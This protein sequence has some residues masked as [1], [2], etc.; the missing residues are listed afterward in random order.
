MGGAAPPFMTPPIYDNPNKTGIANQEVVN[1]LQGGGDMTTRKPQN[2]MNKW[3]GFF[4]KNPFLQNLR[5]RP[6]GAGGYTGRNPAQYGAV[7]R[8]SPVY[9]QDPYA[10]SGNSGQGNAY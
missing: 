6:R 9:E 8:N 2:I 3:S 7:D 1:P 10:S 5:Q 4:S